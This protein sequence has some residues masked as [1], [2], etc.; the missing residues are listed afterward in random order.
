MTNITRMKIQL[1]A[2]LKNR[3]SDARTFE[4][5]AG[6]GDGG[7]ALRI[8]AEAGARYELFDPVTRQGPRV[9]RAK[10]NGR[11]LE[12]FL[13]GSVKADAVIEGYYDDA[14][15]A[16]PAD[17]LTGLTARGDLGVY[18]IDEVF[19]PALST[20]TGD[21]TPI[22]L[23]EG[24]S[25]GWGPSWDWGV[26]G[27]AGAFGVHL[28]K[29]LVASAPAVG[30][31][32]IAGSVTAGPVSGGVMLYAYDAQGTLLGAAAIQSDGTFK[33]AVQGRGDYRGAILL[34]A[35]DSNGNK[36][37][38]LD[39][40][41]ASD[42]NLGSVLRAVGVAQDGQAQFSASGSDA[43]LVIHIT[44]VTELAVIKAGVTTDAAPANPALVLQT[45]QAIAKVLGLGAV[46]ITSRPVTTNSSGFDG[47]NGL[48]AGEKYGLL[49][50]KLSGLDSL[51]GGSLAVSLT[52]LSQNIDTTGEGRITTAGAAMV[53]Q[54]RQQALAALI[55]APAGAEKT[56]ATDTTL[57]RQLLGDVIVTAQALTADGKLA[58]S[59]TALPG[60]TVTVT[61]PDGSLQ[62]VVANEVGVFTLTS[63]AAQPTLEVPLKLTGADGLLQPA[64]HVA[65]SAPQIETGNGKIVS[66]S[67]TPGSTV[68]LTDSGG[69]VIGAAV[70]DALGQWSLEPPIPL[71]DNAKLRASAVDRS[72]NVSGPGAGEVDVEQVSVRLAE[73]ADGYINAVEKA[74]D[75]ISFA[76][77]L[78]ATARPG[79]SV[80]TVVNLPNGSTLTL[81][82]ILT[83]AQ[84][85]DGS[86]TRTL[87]PAQLA[88]DGLYKAAISL[89]TQ[90]GQ[91]APVRSSFIVDTEAPAAPQVSPS[92]GQVIN[93]TA[94]PGTFVTVRDAQ[95]IVIGTAG[96]VGADGNWTVLPAQPLP[97][98]TV[99]S[100]TATDAAG[101]TSEPGANRVYVAALL[102]TGAVDSEGPQLGLLADGSTTNDNSPQL[103][104]TLGAE[105]LPGQSLVVYRQL[106]NGTSVRVGV[107]SINGTAWTFQD[108]DGKGLNAPLADGHYTWQVVVETVSGPVGGLKPS[109]YFDLVIDAGRPAA[110]A[111]LVPEAAGADRFIN[112]AEKA[113]DAGVPI[114]TQ[115]AA[116]A[117]AGDQV[118]TTV[119]LPDG[120]TRVLSTTLKPAD[121]EAGRISQ[122][123][124]Q[125]ALAADGAY[126]ASTILTSAVNGLTSAPTVNSFTLDTVAPVAPTAV[127]ASTAVG[128]SGA[129]VSMVIGKLVGAL[130]LPAG[131]VAVT[132]SVFSP[133][134]KALLG[135]TLQ[136]PLAATTA[137]C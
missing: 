7:Q 38:Y 126:S 70:V 125:S 9:V 82:D 50:T 3:S 116:N 33:I 42:K 118:T 64:P 90:V 16:T 73:A 57:N 72:G 62:A 112:A 117:R 17:S 18:A 36:S 114:V 113:S 60:S 106:D 109:G 59:G 69:E 45:N 23:R 122:L 130:M 105:L 58:V 108:G 29:G 91:S 134:G 92:N 20:L 100:A 55:A 93:G 10:R 119:T 83:A 89:V 115:L 22:V 76:I 44:P 41:T 111:T 95:G 98:A 87:S 2:L 24:G 136:L 31:L 54:G 40:V 96:P 28:L 63:A 84:I 75:G 97:D 133:C 137:V 74:G 53:D 61:L 52:Q 35:V 21:V 1:V 124:A 102:I 66:G 56:F 13:E 86:I 78:P 12:I 51:N 80:S 79:D 14:I 32:T 30:D 77:G 128:A 11:D 68:T 94:E 85:A 48:S 104:G 129:V 101:N 103:A 27:A 39:E 120:S 5:T 46:D 43:A 4:L 99:L 6:M 132:D 121:I 19:R 110:P 107:A 131:S 71:R 15:I 88:T 47:S 25:F 37:N 49:L 67:G 127:L 81:V 135:V 34:K 65:P 26:A 123:F 8:P